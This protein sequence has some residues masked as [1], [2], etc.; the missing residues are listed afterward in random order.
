MQYGSEPTLDKWKA[1]GKLTDI[2]LQPI[3]SC[4]QHHLCCHCCQRS[5]G[6][7]PVRAPRRFLERSHRSELPLPFTPCHL[8]LDIFQIPQPGSYC[9]LN[10]RGPAYSFNHKREHRQA[11]WLSL[12]KPGQHQLSLSKTGETES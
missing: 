6:L 1:G 8:L 12:V 9:L 10:F 4:N 11:S 2:L 7:S 5:I 3:S